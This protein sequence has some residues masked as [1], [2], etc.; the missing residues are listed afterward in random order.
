MYQESLQLALGTQR[1]EGVSCS[2]YE[3]FRHA[4]MYKPGR[5]HG[6]RHVRKAR[7]DGISAHQ[8]SMQNTPFL[9]T[10]LLQVSAVR[11]QVQRWRL[12]DIQSFRV[13]GY[14]ML[15]LRRFNKLDSAKCQAR[16]TKAPAPQL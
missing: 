8:I 11:D 15:K 9:I 4:M 2:Q 1:L 7:Y 5:V 13:L 12:H 10:P 14:F 3:Q 16:L 6:L